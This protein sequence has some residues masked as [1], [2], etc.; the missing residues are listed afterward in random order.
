M[1]SV[2]PMTTQGQTE[3]DDLTGVN[4]AVYDG[5]GVMSSS[6]TALTKMFEWMNATVGNVTA[7]QIQN[8]ALYE[9]DILVVPGGSET[10]CNIELDSEGKEKIKDFVTTGGSFFGICGGATFGANFMHFFNG[11]MNQVLEPGEVIHMTTMHVNQSSTGP[12]LSNCPENV[13]TMYYASQ[14]FVPDE[15][16]SIHTI[17]TYDYN[18]KAGM[19]AFEYQNGTVFLSS[20]HPEYEEDNDR[21]GTTFHDELNDPESEWDLLLQVSRWLIEA[22]PETRPASPETLDFVSIVIISGSAVAIAVVLIVVAKWKVSRP[23]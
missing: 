19:V 11:A 1:I 3:Y 15:G 6:Q 4:V 13:T 22:S 8:D 18:D 9:Y 23:A 5:L 17:A 20:P 21:D 10:T 12:D 2:S 16:F 7:D 14:Y